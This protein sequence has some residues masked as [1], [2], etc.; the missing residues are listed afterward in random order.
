MTAAA[1]EIFGKERHRKRPWVTRE[2]L[3]L[4]DERRDLKK[5]RY[6]A[7]GA[8]EYREA[9]KKI[10]KAVK[11]AKENWICAQCQEIET[12]LNKNNSKRAYQLVKDLTSE[13]QGRSSTIQ[14]SCGQ[15]CSQLP[16]ADLHEKVE[17]AAASLKRGSLSEL[18]IYLTMV[19]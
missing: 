13:K 11:K 2:V 9:D 10:Q 14:E 17:I 6:E 8:K 15:D 12:C 19:K 1:S 18:I 3:N 4:C 7:E 5:K 16:Q